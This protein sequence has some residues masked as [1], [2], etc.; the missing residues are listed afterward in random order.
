MKEP[1]RFSL[2]YSIVSIV[3]LVLLQMIFHVLSTEIFS[4]TIWLY[5]IYS[6][7]GVIVFLLFGLFSRRYKISLYIRVIC[8]G[9]L[10]LFVLNSVPLLGERKF[11]TLDMIQGLLTHKAEFIDVGIHVIGLVSFVIASLI[12]ITYIRWLR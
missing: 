8:Y 5:I 3:I 2:I 7:A 9:V 12:S 11:L 1:I 10:C 6:I 4:N